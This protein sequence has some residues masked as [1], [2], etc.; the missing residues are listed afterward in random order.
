[1]I[2]FQTKIG[3]E[4]W[5]ESNRTNGPPDRRSSNSA[6]RLSVSSLWLCSK[7]MSKSFNGWRLIIFLVMAIQRD[8]ERTVTD[9]YATGDVLF[10]LVSFFSVSPLTWPI[11]KAPSPTVRERFEPIRCQFCSAYTRLAPACCQCGLTPSTSGANLNTRMQ[12]GTLSGNN[13][14]GETK[15]GTEPRR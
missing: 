2:E 12:A 4:A 7:K 1:M 3:H 15:N 13:F 5:S 10:A 11:E 8:A 6:R 9:C 14:V